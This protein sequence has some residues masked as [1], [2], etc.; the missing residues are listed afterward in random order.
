MHVPAGSGRLSS[1][2]KISQLRVPDN[3]FLKSSSRRRLT[4]LSDEGL[5][6]IDGTLGSSFL[7]EWGG[8]F[9]QLGLFLLVVRPDR[10]LYREYVLG[11]LGFH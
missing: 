6:D 2:I 10:C 7:N 4:I 8:I 9:L 5:N 3:Q 1:D 11:I